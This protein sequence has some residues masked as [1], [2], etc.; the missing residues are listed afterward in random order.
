MRLIYQLFH[1]RQAVQHNGGLL[2]SE[3]MGHEA[4]EAMASFARPVVVRDDD[5]YHFCSQGA[6]IAKAFKMLEWP[7]GLDADMMLTMMRFIMETLVFR[8]LNF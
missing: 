2:A 4:L 1:P 6:N 7:D 3:L 8:G 5:P